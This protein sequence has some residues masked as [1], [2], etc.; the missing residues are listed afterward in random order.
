MIAAAL[1]GKATGLVAIGAVGGVVASDGVK[2]FVR[3]DLIHG[4]A[5]TVTSWGLRG[6]R[7][8]ESGAEKARL[9]TSDIV[10]EA[11]AKVGE[12]SPAP[13]SAAPAHNHEH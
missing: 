1:L 8:A 5:V 12:Q 9:T 10:S 11:R 13:G 3:G 4:A 2:K 7:L 6:A